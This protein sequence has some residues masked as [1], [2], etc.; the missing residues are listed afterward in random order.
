MADSD[1]RYTQLLELAQNQ[2]YPPV[3]RWQP[4]REGEIDIRIGADGTWHHEGSPI[5]RPALVRLF[6]TIL[7]REQE[8]YFLVTP[9]E[10]LRIV[11]EDVPFVAV[12]VEQGTG[13]EG[14]E[15]LFT[16]N[17]GDYVVADVAHPI[18]SREHEGQQIP[19]VHVRDGLEARI[20]RPL[21]YRLAE[22]CEPAADGY[23][24]S[25]RGTR[26]RLG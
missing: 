18:S 3:N 14:A 23:W 5:P 19:Y 24:L 7:R 2:T 6:S 10:K 15:L 22:L 13:A 25:S 4:D 9:A 17:V 1:D 20:S 26:F 12:D 16:T 8:S 21:F 11:V